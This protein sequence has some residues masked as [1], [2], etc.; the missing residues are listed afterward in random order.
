MDGTAT[1]ISEESAWW[2]TLLFPATTTYL[3]L[4]QPFLRRLLRQTVETFRSVVPFNDRFRRLEI[5]AYTLNRRGEWLAFGLSAAIGWVVLDPPWARPSY[6]TMVYSFIGDGLVFGLSGWHIYNA[7]TRTKRLAAMYDQVQT[8]N[9]FKQRAPFEPI[10]RWS[11]G[12]A[13]CFIG[14]IVVSAL[15]IPTDSLINST[16]IIIYGALI[17][18]V[19]LVFIFSRVPASL[20]TQFRVFRA[21]TLFV[22]VAIVGT[23]GFNQF[24]EWPI[25]EA[26]YATIITM[27]TIGY[28]DFSPESPKGRLFTIFLSL[29]AI[30]IGGYAVTS[31]ASFII[32]GNFHRFIQGKKVDKK[33]D[34]MRDHYILCGAGRVGKQ[35]A[36]E[37]YKS[38]KSF[39][40][41][42][43]SST[44]LEE[45][46]REAEIPYVQGDATQDES[47]HLAGVERAKGLVAALSDD[48]DNVFIVLSARSLNPKL[49]IISRVTL[50]KN[51]KKLEKAGANIIISPN[52]ASGRRM[53][54][55]MLHSEVVTLLDEMLQAEQQTGQTLRLE[56]V[57]VDEIKI[58]ALVERLERGE[59]RIIDIGQR[60]EL[61]VVAIKR[62]QLQENGDS[63]IYTPKGNTRLQH[64]DVLIVIGTPEQRIELQYNVLSQTNF[65]VWLSKIWT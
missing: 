44:V 37:F 62:Q 7:L 20:L 38:Q 41:I 59:L 36:I 49:H 34:Q 46:L 32:E 23:I 2:Y 5:D 31:I 33:I 8:L 6:A 45:L 13:G 43:Q 54:S 39:V 50:N 16:T 48:K 60:T 27:T 21:F 19:I 40:V 24:E 11:I 17:L 53:V 64:G 61:M 30:G 58:P 56:E 28:G 25:A 51:R 1:K 57:Y 47:L 4:I 9:L 10:A 52:E 12:V 22:M 15:F 63:Y 55:E 3:L 18:S 35:I 26:L 29:I 42:E 14:G 65:E